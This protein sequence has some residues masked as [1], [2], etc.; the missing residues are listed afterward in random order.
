MRYCDFINQTIS[1]ENGIEWNYY[2]NDIA[3]TDI[4]CGEVSSE[5]IKQYFENGEKALPLLLNPETADRFITNYFTAGRKESVLSYRFEEQY[6]LP[7]ERA[8]HTVSGF[9]LG[10]LI[11]NCINSFTP[12]SLVSVNHFPLAYLWF[13]T[14]LY[15]DYGYSVT[16]K[17]D[18][19]IRYPQRAPIPCQSYTH[20][21][22]CHPGEYQALKEIKRKLGINLSPF[23]QLGAFT[24]FFQDETILLIWNMLC[25]WS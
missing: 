21:T 20:Y 1:H 9:F 18:C 6:Q 13:L 3:T 2:R 10:L 11:E 25:L 23:S 22:Y 4:F 16:E 17:E 7:A 15:H 19:P 14:Y 24:F 5:F 8:I 12:L